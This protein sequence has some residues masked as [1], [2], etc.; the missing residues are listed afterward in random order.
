MDLVGVVD[1][2]PS[3]GRICNP[4]W[5]AVAPRVDE[6]SAANCDPMASNDQKPRQF[7]IPIGPLAFPGC[8]GRR[9]AAEINNELQVMTEM[10]KRML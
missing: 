5:G 7:K 4:D 6:P 1:P 2:F 9:I 10:A 3:P 8:K